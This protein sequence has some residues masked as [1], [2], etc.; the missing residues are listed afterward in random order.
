M[1][2]ERVAVV[3]NTVR[4]EAQRVGI[5]AIVVAVAV[6]VVFFFLSKSGLGSAGSSAGVTTGAATTPSTDM[7]PSPAAT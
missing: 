3:N 5:G 4:N 7:A 1:W 2:R 6:L